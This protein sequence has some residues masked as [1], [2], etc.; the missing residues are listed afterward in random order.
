MGVKVVMV[1]NG[2]INHQ[3]L[4]ELIP[5]T[6]AW[7][8]DIKWALDKTAQKLSAVSS[9]RPV[10]ETAKTIF[11]KEKHLEITTNIVSGYNDSEKELRAIAD[12]IAKE[13]SPEISWHISRAFPAYKLPDLEVTP[14]ET[15][16][17]A[18]AVGRAAGLT[19]IYLGN[20]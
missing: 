15:L 18:Q 17:K 14:M 20:I 5:Y 4:Q 8:L 11:L 12:F 7:S 6:D 13:L 19:N 10:L 1:S 2:Y 9:A 3:P 16:K